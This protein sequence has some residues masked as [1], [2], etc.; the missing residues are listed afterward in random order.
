[1]VLK[2]NPT[3]P[4]NEFGQ[5]E[6]SPETPAPR[7]FSWVVGNTAPTRTITFPEFERRR[8]FT[9]DA[10]MRGAAVGRLLAPVIEPL[11]GMRSHATSVSADEIRHRGAVALSARQPA[12]R[13][14]SEQWLAGD[15]TSMRVMV[16][17][18]RLTDAAAW[19]PGRRQDQAR[20]FLSLQVTRG[21]V[22]RSQ[23]KSRRRSAISQRA[24]SC[25]I[26][27]LVRVLAAPCVDPA[28]RGHAWRRA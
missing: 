15:V 1:M 12:Q 11:R 3:A 14:L 6:L 8:Q 9:P 18:Q 23:R 4:G 20:T 7:S 26:A 21:D 22:A 16:E 5:L 25:R 28:G 19:E 2:R 27:G 10:E 24:W 17:R 13:P